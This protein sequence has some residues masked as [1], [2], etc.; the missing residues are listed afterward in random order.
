MQSRHFSNRTYVGV[1][2]GHIWVCVGG[3][4]RV[5]QTMTYVGGALQEFQKPRT[6]WVRQ[7][8]E[9]QEAGQME[10]YVEGNGDYQKPRLA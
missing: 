2:A 10:A 4:T 6:V 3:A 7:D 5:S 9:S 1:Q 8:T